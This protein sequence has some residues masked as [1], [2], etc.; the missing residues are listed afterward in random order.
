MDS[1]QDC[2]KLMLIGL[3]TGYIYVSKCTGHAL[4]YLLRR[5]IY[6]W[7]WYLLI[8]V[9]YIWFPTIPDIFK[10]TEVN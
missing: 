6:I 4:S 8:W 1:S 5:V 3:E 7:L 9:N 10:I 2:L